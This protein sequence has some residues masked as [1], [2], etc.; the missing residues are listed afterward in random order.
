MTDASSLNTLSSPDLILDHTDGL[1][2]H[3]KRPQWGMAIMVWESDG[4]RAYQFQDGERRIFKEGFYDMMQ[5]VDP[6]QETADEMQ[7]ILRRRLDDPQEH[8][9]AI[10]T[11]IK[12]VYPFETQLTIFNILYP[13]GFN[14]AAWRS[15]KRGE[16]A[17]K[18][19]KR[20][21][22]AAIKEARARLSKRRVEQLIEQNCALEV[23]DD[24]LAVM[25]YTDLVGGSVRNK[26]ASLPDDERAQ[27]G[28]ALAMM[29]HADNPFPNRLDRFVQTMRKVLGR[30]PEWRASTVLP[31]LL[32]PDDVVCIHSSTFRKQAGSI[33]PKIVYAKHATANSYKHFRKVAREVRT[34]LIDAGHEPQDML[35]V[36][37]FIQT[38]LRPSASKVLQG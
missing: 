38:T 32:D 18:V 17:A 36:H 34:R 7:K 5:E 25:R 1:Y 11:P 12:A 19:L 13:K 2:V 20:H 10:H 16:D 26:W 31:A 33:A 27:F 29:L 37:D 30:H 3:K 9:R 21:R 6:P 23:A 28:E 15:E 4:K 14:G 22:D 24:A 8:K 35:D